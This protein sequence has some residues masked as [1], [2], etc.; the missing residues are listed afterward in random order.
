MELNDLAPFRHRRRQAARGTVLSPFDRLHEEMDR[1]FDDFLPQASNGREFDSR[2]GALASIDLSEFDDAL[3][4]KADLPGMQEADID[5]MLRDGALVISGERKH[6]SEEKKKNYYRSER[7]YGAF[8]RN[9]PL[10]CEVDEDKIEAQFKKGVLTVY[11]PKTPAAK[12]NS[13]KIE[14]RAA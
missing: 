1:L 12:N 5:V 4:I 8:T 9:V 10:P 2:L 6:E 7:A 14:I 11:M 3:E 13:R